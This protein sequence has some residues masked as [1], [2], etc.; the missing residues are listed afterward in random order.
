MPEECASPH[1]CTRRIIEVTQPSLVRLKPSAALDLLLPQHAQDMLDAVPLQH[2][3]LPTLEIWIFRRVPGILCVFEDERDL[4]VP[5]DKGEIC[6]RALVA[7]Q[8]GAAG[9]VGVEDGSHTVDLVGVAFAGGREGFWVE[10]VEPVGWIKRGW[11][12]G[13]SLSSI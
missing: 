9:Q 12:D 6:V 7:H 5:H 13:S 3:L 4:S 2:S 8:P 1:Q 11:L 10:D